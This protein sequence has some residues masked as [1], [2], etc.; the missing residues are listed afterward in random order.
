MSK[1]PDTQSA[2][3]KKEIGISK[4]DELVKG[5]DA[6]LSEEELKRVAGGLKSAIKIG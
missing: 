3:P 5:S 2:P 6:E 1:K 4:A